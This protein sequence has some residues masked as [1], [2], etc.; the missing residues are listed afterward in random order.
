[1]DEAH[2]ET[3]DSIMTWDKEEIRDFI[4]YITRKHNLSISQLVQDHV[5][6]EF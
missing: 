3:L 4:D 5:G 1:M 2:Y 6:E